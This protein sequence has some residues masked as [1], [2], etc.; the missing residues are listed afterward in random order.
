MWRTAERPGK[1]KTMVSPVRFRP[2]ALPLSSRPFANSFAGWFQA[3]F[4]TRNWQKG[5][6][7]VDDHVVAGRVRVAPSV[8]DFLV[9]MDT[10]RRKKK[11][12][13]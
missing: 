2:S 12:T 5:E 10:V 7:V 9:A 6:R 8:D 1:L 3:W 13:A 11:R 4:W